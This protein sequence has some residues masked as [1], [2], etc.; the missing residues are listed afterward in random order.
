LRW[1]R[2][3]RR[4]LAKSLLRTYQAERRVIFL[5][6]KGLT[7][8]NNYLSTVVG[9]LIAGIFTV[10]A[11][12]ALFRRA[13]FSPSDFHSGCAGIIGTALALVLTLSIVPAQ[14]A[15]DVF[16]TAILKLYARDR[17]LWKVFATL[18]ALTLL[19]MHGRLVLIHVGR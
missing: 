2:F 16:S 14:K 4:F 18:A 9:V 1:E 19:S 5:G 15:A 17:D 8:L 6:S 11:S 12:D 13:I 7:T 3:K 10:T